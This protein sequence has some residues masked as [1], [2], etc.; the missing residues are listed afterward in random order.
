MIRRKIAGSMQVAQTCPLVIP[1]HPATLESCWDL[2]TPIELS[3]RTQEMMSELRQEAYKQAA[4]KSLEPERMAWTGSNHIKSNGIGAYKSGGCGQ[5][6]WPE[7]EK[8]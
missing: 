7:V 5:G 8:A 6:C 4:T 2:V 1:H 3:V